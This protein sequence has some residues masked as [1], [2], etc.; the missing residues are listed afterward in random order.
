MTDKETQTFE[1]KVTSIISELKAD[2]S[3]NLIIPDELNLDEATKFAVVTEKR[4]RDTQSAFTKAQQKLKTLTAENN[5]AWSTLEKEIS[6][7][8]TVEEKT[9]LE[10]LKSVDIDKWR[11]RLNELEGTKKNKVAETRAKVSA[12]TA[13]EA[14]LEARIEILDAYNTANPDLKLTDDV[15]ENEI[16]PKYTKQ[17]EKGEITFEEFIHKCA[18]FLKKGKIITPGTEADDEVDLGKANGSG[19][20]PKEALEKSSA[21]DYTKE[22]Y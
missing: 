4:R 15:I 6:L 8:L 12:K 3:G 10:E 5:E 11:K 16:P 7:D 2:D 18:T 13:K 22:T 14:E 19:K 20:I 9:E 17:L 1:Q 21:T